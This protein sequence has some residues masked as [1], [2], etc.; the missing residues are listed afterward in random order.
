MRIR[1]GSGLAAV[2]LAGLAAGALAVAAVE[3]SKTLFDGS[4]PKG[5][6]LCDGKPLPQKFVQ[7]DGLN[8]HDTGSYITVY[9]ESD[10]AS[11]VASVTLD[12]QGT[13]DTPTWTN[14]APAASVNEDLSFS[15]D[16][17]VTS[18]SLKVSDLALRGPDVTRILGC[19]PGPIVGQVLRG[20][21]E[22][23]LDD[24]TLN[25]VERLTELVPELA[26]GPRPA[27]TPSSRST[28]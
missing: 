17:V 7:D 5:W 25:T 10:T 16:T 20:L 9:D 13:N 28:A 3:D 24:P 2:A 15:L 18:T 11:H 6:I 21:L 23:V 14:T 12:V 4:S 27:C 8:P 19:P 1:L 26:R 22:R